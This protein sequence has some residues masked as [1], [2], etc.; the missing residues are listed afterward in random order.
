[1]R[2][3]LEQARGLLEPWVASYRE[4]GRLQKL[5]PLW[6]GRE[7]EALVTEWQA[8]TDRGLNWGA[9]GLVLPPIPQLVKFLWPPFAHL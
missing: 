7:V 9:G 6:A 4:L 2:V 3:G 8:C 5:G 1:M